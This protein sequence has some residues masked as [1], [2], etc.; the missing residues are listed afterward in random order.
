LRAGGRIG[1]SRIYLYG[2]GHAVN[3]LLH[4]FTDDEIFT[5]AFRQ[6]VPPLL[7]AFRPDI[8]VA[9]LGVDTFRSD[10]LSDLELTTEGFTTMVEA[11]RELSLPWV[12]LGGGCC[13]MRHIVVIGNIANEH[14]K[15]RNASWD[16]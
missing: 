4:P 13:A 2:Q 15:R 10:P 12:A 9:Q 3:V 5:G 14:G 8:L 6:V 11:F 1:A 7:S 16:F